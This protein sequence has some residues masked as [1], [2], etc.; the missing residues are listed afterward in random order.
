MFEDCITKTIS[1]NAESHKEQDDGK[2]FLVGQSTV[3]LQTIF[4]VDV[5]KNTEK[6]QKPK[7]LTWLKKAASPTC[8]AK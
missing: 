4:Q 7:I 6:K 1:T 8:F 2:R 3:E 5:T